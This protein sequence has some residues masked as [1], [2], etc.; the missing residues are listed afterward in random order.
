[1]PPVGVP[2]TPLNISYILGNSPSPIANLPG[3][4]EVFEGNQSFGPGYPP[5]ADQDSPL[6]VWPFQSGR[7]LVYAPRSYEPIKFQELFALAQNHDI[8]AL[9]IETR[10]DQIEKLDWT[11]RPRKGMEDGRQV[12]DRIAAMTEFFLHPEA[13]KEKPDNNFAIWLRKLLHQALVIDAPALEVRRT[14]GGSI[15]GFDVIDGSLLNIN[16]DITGRRPKPPFPAFTQVVYGR[17]WKTLTEDQIIY[18][19]RNPRVTSLYGY[20]PVEQLLNTINV[21]LR[22]QTQQL[23]YFSET[24]IPAGLLTAPQGWT[25][26]QI[27]TF[28]D[29][30][31]S[32]LATP[33]ERSKL[34]WGP[35]GAGYHAFKTPPIKDEQDEWLARVVCFAFSL[36]PTAF[37]QQMNRATADT[38][39]EVA[40]EEG[41]APLMGWVKRL[42]DHLLQKRMGQPDL[43][44]A[45]QEE[46]SVDP[47]IQS[48][49]LSTYLDRGA[50]TRNELRAQIGFEN[51]P[52]GNVLTVQNGGSALPLR[53]IVNPPEPAPAL[54]FGAPVPGAGGSDAIEDADEDQEDGD[55]ADRDDEREVGKN[56]PA[57]FAKARRLR[58]AAVR[59]EALIAR[60][61]RSL[62]RKLRSFFTI[63]AADVAEQAWA[64]ISEIARA[65]DGDGHAERIVR[66]FALGDWSVLENPTAEELEIAYRDGVTEAL[67]LVGFDD[68]STVNEARERM[69]LPPVPEGDEVPAIVNQVNERSVVWARQRAAELVTQIS[70]NTRNMLRRTI[71][72]GIEEGWSAKR[73]ASEIAVSPAFSKDRAELIAQTEI[74]NSNNAGNL[75]AYLESGVVDKKEWLPAFGACIICL[76]N[77]AIGAIP[78][79]KQFPSGHQRPGAHPRC[80]CS[81]LPVIEDEDD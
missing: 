45:W 47:L 74:I 2:A 3:A 78:L 29:W 30:F 20:S 7:N 42:I 59:N 37:V 54:P 26:D 48:Q 38:A 79:D 25:P 51:V 73:L 17:P 15:I 27:R 14:R 68:E 71:A 35:Y 36:P 39:Q 64:R 13:D 12:D 62:S 34:I 21:A 52:D 49:V 6:R 19:P 4:A 56:S 53:D 75:A 41:L 32:V 23:H 57:P 10:K 44:F 61:E 22:R 67:R 77:A 11:I 66:S 69:D 16:I 31:D 46:Q 65:A 43:E 55:R 8:T 40:L 33:T 50:I 5:V 24:N 80:R 76:N 28:Q 60:G 1:M 70:E 72:Q 9:C 58:Q 63:V 18:Y 81:L